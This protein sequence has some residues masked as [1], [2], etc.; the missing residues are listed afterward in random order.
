MPEIVQT[1]GNS[2]IQHGP[3]NDRIYLMKASSKEA[4]SLPDRL[5]ELAS[6]KGYSKILGKVPERLKP[7]FVRAGY[8]EEARIPDYYKDGETC[9]LLSQFLSDERAVPTD[10]EL[11]DKVLH[12]ALDT[13]VLKAAPDPVPEGHVLRAMTPDDAEEMASVYRKVFS[14]YPLSIHNP[15]YLV[16]AMSSHIQYFG[17]L[18]DNRLIALASS[19]MD[20]DAL[21]VEMTDF[22]TLPECR[23]KGLAVKLL[24]RME[25]TMREK[26]LTAAYTIAR[27]ISYGMNITFAKLGYRYTGTLVNNAQISGSMESMNVWY[28]PI[29]TL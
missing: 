20:M 12:T 24:Y 11:M 6:Q 9:W 21:A 14:R 4:Q 28:K 10:N 2:L 1:I 27:A 22:A 7:L 26:G 25:N 16:H 15:E 18:V 3:E 17:V 13:R 5:Y 19:E 8:E 29:L 23:G